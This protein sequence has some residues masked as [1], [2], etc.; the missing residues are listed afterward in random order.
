MS[1][2]LE[3]A[4]QKIETANDPVKWIEKEFYIPETKHDPVLRGR[5]KLWPHQADIIRE[6]F[7]RD[8]NGL[9]KY[10]TIIWS[11]IKKSWK[12]SIAAAVNLFRA[13]HTEWGEFYVIAND[14]KQAESRVHKYIRRAIELN[15]RLRKRYRKHGY[16]ITAPNGSIIEAIP[17]DPSGE[18]GSNADQ[19]TFSELWGALEE[20]KE[21]MWSEMN[22]PPDKFGKAFRWVESYAG[23]VGKSNL[24][25]SLYDI[26]VTKGELLWP[27]R[28]YPVTGGGESQ[29]EVYVNKQARM[30][31][32]W[33]T[34]PRLPAQTKE[35]YSTEA[36][37]MPPNQFQRIHRNQWSSDSDTYIPIEWWDACDRS[38]S[39]PMVPTKH[40]MVISVDA[41]VS[42]DS[43]SLWM[44]CRHPDHAD[45][46]LEYLV[47]IWK[48]PT[49]GKMD[50]DATLW[51]ELNRLINEYNIVKIVYD[52]FQLHYLMTRLKK[53][54]LV[55]VSAFSQHAKRASADKQLRDLVAG[56][57]YWH[58]NHPRMREHV[59]NADAKI[60]DQDQKMRIVKRSEE[61]KVDG[62]VAGSMGTYEVLRLNL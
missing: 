8:E 61:L 55:W 54:R 50:Y 35:Y 1:K 52:E 60:D 33:G 19:V 53:A 6:A 59:L 24:L 51:P 57:R 21:A 7:S 56:Q 29:I 2:R 38:D 31:C 58:K 16:K 10:S 20:A 27:G 9:Y 49:G 36:M 3:Q 18:A 5:F 43:T 22:I 12:S 39:F 37:T 46:V 26:G 17:V 11:D 13:E 15:P 44:G 25:K 14:L 45:E 34:V 28:M 48:P 23:F 40:P 4:A 32:Y 41:A 47:Q 62:V 30:L 42:G